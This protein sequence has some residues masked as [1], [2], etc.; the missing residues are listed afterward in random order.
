M[1]ASAV[2][3][4]LLEAAEELDAAI[5]AEP[6]GKTL[7]DSIAWMAKVVA[8]AEVTSAKIRAVCDPKRGRRRSR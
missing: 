5:K 2:R 8:C 1:K 7:G 4:W 3:E 6:Q